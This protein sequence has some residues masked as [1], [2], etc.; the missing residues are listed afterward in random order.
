MSDDSD[1]VEAIFWSALCRA[2]AA[3]PA[4]LDAACAGEGRLRQ[5]VEERGDLGIVAEV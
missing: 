1:R 5:Q 2:A 4:F 3:R